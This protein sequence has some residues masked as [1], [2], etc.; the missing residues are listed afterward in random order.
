MEYEKMLEEM[1]ETIETILELLREKKY[2]MAREEILKNN[3]VDIAE[4]L[5]EVIETLGEDMGIIVL[6]TL[7]KDVLAEV[8]ACLPSDD[9]VSIITRITDKEISYIIN[10]LDFDDMIDVLEE[11]PA[12]IVSK[13][14]LHASKEERKLI[15]TFLNYPENSAG[16]L[17]TPEYI[18]LPMDMT[19]GQAMAH[20]K[21]VGMD[22]ETIYTCYV[23]DKGRKLAGVVSL[24][25]LVIADED[26]PIEKYMHSED[27]VYVH[28]TDDQE[29]VS[30]QFTR[31]GFLAMPVLDNED[32]LVGIITVDDIMDIIEEEATEDV[33]KM[34]GVAAS[35]DEYMDM[36]VFRHVKSRLPWLVFLM[37]SLMVTG[38]IIT[39][40][41]VLLSEVLIL[42]SYLP[43]LMGT[44]G[45]SGSQAAALVVRSL[46]VGDLTP[47][48]A[49]RVLW[50]E[51][52]IGFIVGIILSAIN[53]AKV[54]FLDQQT[55]L[56]AFTVSLA[57]LIILVIA[58]VLGSMLPMLAKKI[59]ID[60][61]LMATPMIASVS[62]M[63]T[64]IVYFLLASMLL[65]VG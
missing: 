34:A 15:N 30:S 50:K 39:R 38:L 40:F 49:G 18:S 6:R 24:R 23:K 47:G 17:M 21:S 62:D 56:V 42:V 22:R 29:Y 46:A 58:K 4:I 63:I 20:I 36:G 3:P 59:G 65:G 55:V 2:V 44:G 25:T 9:Q 60:P 43:L 54:F 37:V 1:E 31:Y 52:R 7:P 64:V 57:I 51:F 26:D 10:E 5:E 28:V 61:A 32:R 33:Q 53:F 19:V 11:L 13:I 8:F 14:L 12:G 45:N 16:S 35:T 27:M 41:E 48:D